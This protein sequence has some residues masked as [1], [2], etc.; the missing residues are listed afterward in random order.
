MPTQA[1]DRAADS[2][3]V[4]QNPSNV[5]CGLPGCVLSPL[6][7]DEQKQTNEQTYATVMNVAVTYFGN[8]F[9]RFANEHRGDSMPA[10]YRRI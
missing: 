1:L 5:L 6:C 10:V 3:I 9:A 8:R 2:G 4:T 7:S